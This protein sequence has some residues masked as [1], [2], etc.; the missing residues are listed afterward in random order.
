MIFNVRYGFATNSSST[1]S[2]IISNDKIRNNPPEDEYYGWNHFTLSKKAN[3]KEYL[4]GILHQHLSHLIGDEMA[5][6]LACVWCNLENDNA[7]IGVIDH[8]SVPALPLN[9][10]N[11]GLNRQFFDEYQKFLLKESVIILGGNDN[12]TKVHPLACKFHPF[13]IP[14]IYDRSNSNLVARKD[15]VNGYWVI[16]DREEGTKIRLA[17]SEEQPKPTKASAPELVDLKI[18]NYCEHSCSFCYQNSSKGGKHADV[19][20][21]DSVIRCL[22]EHQ[23]FEVALGGG[24]PTTHPNFSGI[25]R[26][27]QYYGV[28]PNFTVS[29]LDWLKDPDKREKWLDFCGG[30]AY[31]TTSSYGVRELG[32]AIDRYNLPSQK[33]QVQIIEGVV[34]ELQFARILEECNYHNLTLTILGYK[35]IGRGKDFAEKRR[36]Y[37]FDWISLV[38]K[39]WNDNRCPR[40][41]VD[42]AIV[43]KHQDALKNIGVDDIFFTTREGS[44]SCYIDA[45]KQEIGPSSYDPDKMESFT[46]LDQFIPKFST[47]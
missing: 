8:Q 33:F 22:S 40:I 42:T 31:S 47:F 10:D 6:D 25:L 30:I 24:D 9:W 7:R 38:N 32:F 45:V 1:H 43:A 21:I 34:N 5:K 46:E 19:S 13:I 39:A 36:L 3:K 26:T 35:Q 16:F 28:V 29:N 14:M 11:R 23:V 12:E 17:F 37:K 20:Y 27:C 18:T 41:G 4:A 44:F 2:I 15:E